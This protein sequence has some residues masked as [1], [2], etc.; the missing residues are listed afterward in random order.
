M[1]IIDIVSK[2][3][4]DSKE[5]LALVYTPGVAKSSTAIYEDYDKVFDLTNRSNS[6]AVLSFDYFESLKRAVYLKE[7]YG[8]DAFPLE[9]KKNELKEGELDFVINNIMPNFMGVDKVLIEGGAYDGAF[10]IPKRSKGCV[11]SDD[12]KIETLEPVELR[13]LLG[14]VIETNVLEVQGMFDNSYKPVAIVS[15]GSAVLG[16]GNIGAEAGLP[17]MEGKAV[18]F[19]DLGGVNAMPLCLKTQVPSEIERIVFLLENSFSG[20]N[21]E[22]ISAPRCFEVEQN[23]IEKLNI[24]VFHDDQHGTAIV[25]LA[26]LLNAMKVA[27]KELDKVK[28]V[29]SG[30]GAAGQAIAR[31]LIKMREL[32]SGG[33]NGTCG[34]GGAN[35]LMFDKFGAVYKGRK[36]NDP[37]LEKMAEITNFEGFKGS[38][39]DGIKGADVFIG[40]STKG[41]LSPEMVKSMADD[42]VIFAIA[43]PEPEILPDVALKAGAKIAASGRSDFNNQINNSLVFPGLFRGVLENGVKKIDDKVKLQAALA[44]AQIVSDEE[45][46]ENYIIPDALDKRVPLGLQKI[47]QHV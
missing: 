3:K 36:E 21:L 40:V 9:I 38:L 31:L 14:G 10:N 24:P 34:G 12:I 2:V 47:F 45:L 1:K 35:I 42:P 20:I 25:V 19:K 27:G 41:I 22:D 28:I 5:L 39:K 18:L 17:V 16:L 23:L 26:G 13:R 7:T 44:L 6:V 46:N 37:S 29:F 43:N 30:A 15:D 4:V 8:A 11:L 32:I 33:K